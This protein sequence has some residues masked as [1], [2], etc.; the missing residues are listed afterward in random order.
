MLNGDSEPPLPLRHSPDTAGASVAADKS[1]LQLQPVVQAGGTICFSDSAHVSLS[2][3]QNVTDAPAQSQSKAVSPARIPTIPPTTLPNGTP[4]QAPATPCSNSYA[5]Q[6]PAAH[7][8][9]YESASQAAYQPASQAAYQP[10]SQ[11]AEQAVNYSSS[12]SSSLT[13]AQ[14][15][16]SAAP[17][18][19]GS[20]ASPAPGNQGEVWRS[21][22]AYGVATST[23]STIMPLSSYRA[24]QSL[25]SFK[26]FT[27]VDKR[28]TDSWRAK[29]LKDLED[30]SD[31]E[32]GT[33]LRMTL[34][35][36]SEHDSLPALMQQWGLQ[37][38][39]LTQDLHLSS[40]QAPV[41][42]Q[43]T[44]ESSTSQTAALG[45]NYLSSTVLLSPK[46]QAKGASLQGP[47]GIISSP[48][49]VSPATPP[50][51]TPPQSDLYRS[52]DS[53]FQQLRQAQRHDQLG[54]ARGVQGQ[55]APSQAELAAEHRYVGSSG[56]EQQAGNSMLPLQSLSLLSDSNLEV[57]KAR[58]NMLDIP[59]AE[60]LD[61][62]LDF[63]NAVCGEQQNDTAY[64]PLKVKI[65]LHTGLRV[66]FAVLFGHPAI[67]M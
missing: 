45:D 55:Q 61:S 42:Y 3:S 52:R 36:V 9:T 40:H 21:N 43:Q 67:F 31:N 23:S 10:A 7:Q 59:S 44:Y 56:E 25:P 51:H 58:S 16:S 54:E 60:L 15:P 48:R 26:A 17:S 12:F 20:S 4:A 46:T 64:S 34:P 65:R 49:P 22:P 50:A 63:A 18:E 2:Q 27:S 35:V 5:A 33:D 11:A 30:E 1:S 29:L 47:A 24:S 14:Q 62:I 57:V 39:D 37:S 66:C 41:P 28:L 6:E 8:S 53:P 19:V 13:A 38:T 32:Q